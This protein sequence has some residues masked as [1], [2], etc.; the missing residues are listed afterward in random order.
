M[1]RFVVLTSIS[2]FACSCL[3]S[4]PTPV[5]S[6]GPAYGPAYGPS[7]ELPSTVNLYDQYQFDTRTL[8]ATPSEVQAQNT[9]VFSEL[10]KLTLPPSITRDDFIDRVAAQAVLTQIIQHPVVG[11]RALKLYDPK[12]CIGFCFGRAMAIHIDL[13]AR[14]LN[15]DA[16]RKAYL[17]GEM[18]Y[19]GIKWGFHVATIIRMEDGSWLAIDPEAGK[20]LTLQEWFKEYEAISTDKKL[21]LYITEADKFGA[22]AASYEPSGLADPFYNN[23]FTDM[24]KDFRERKLKTEDMFRPTSCSAAFY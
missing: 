5:V 9:A 22:S 19:G 14:G 1:K 15:K 24:L 16:I 17:V 23:Y 3:A 13:L 8:Q 20:L 11:M 2:L 12:N 7:S 21:R 10:D 6:L 18:Q 4:E